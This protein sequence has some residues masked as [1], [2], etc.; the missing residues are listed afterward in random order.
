MYSGAGIGDSGCLMCTV[1]VTLYGVSSDSIP[2]NA[3]AVLLYGSDDRS[4]QLYVLR[5]SVEDNNITLTLADTMCMTDETL[6]LD[7][8]DYDEDGY[9]T[10]DML[11]RKLVPK[12]GFSGFQAA[13]PRVAA[14]GSLSRSQ[15][16]GKSSR[17]LLDLLS[18]AMVGYW[19]AC[20]TSLVFCELGEYKYSYGVTLHSKVIMRGKRN[21]SSIV[22]VNGSSY[23]G[24]QMPR[25]LYVDTPFASKN[26]LNAVI[27]SADYTYQSWKCE[28]CVVSNW[29]Y[30]GAVD[31]ADKGT[32]F[33]RNIT[34]TFDRTGI[35]LSASADEI[36]E[37]EVAYKS[38][39]QRQIENRVELDTINGSTGIRRDGLYFFED[40]YSDM[41]KEEK[42]K[43]KY[44]FSASKGVT[45]YSGAMVSKVVPK[46][47]TW[48]S[49]KSEAVVDY[50]GR[51]YKYAIRRD[52]DGNVTS[53]AKEEIK[54]ETQ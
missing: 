18:K 51:K 13:A 3:P 7:D 53:F 28:H 52:S 48:N 30:P 19:F 20:D 46:S 23:Y 41:P 25:A 42:K 49:D 54:E 44:S 2:L 9:I 12:C 38:E 24:L 40:G 35:Y 5:R 50:G 32:L 26:L 10:A 33:C 47:A 11:L 37:N 27:G 14:V 29:V 45:E 36:C 21:I 6:I 8:S 39:L 34:M 43:A 31:L 15:C 22:L 17:D 4:P 16:E 1:T